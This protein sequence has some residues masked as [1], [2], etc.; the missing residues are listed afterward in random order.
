MTQSRADVI[1]TDAQIDAAIARANKRSPKLPRV[2]AAAYDHANDKVRVSL[3]NG[4]DVGF[5][6]RLIQGLTDARPDQLVKIQILGPGTGLFWPDLDVA[7][8]VLQMLTG[9]FGTRRWMAEIAARGGAA[10]SEKKAEAARINGAKSA[11]RPKKVIPMP[12]PD[13]KL[14]VELWLQANQESFRSRRSATAGRKKYTTAKKSSAGK[15][16]R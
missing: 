1:T 7:H 15:K 8:D 3:G 11:G 13:R 12:V 6:R 5:P 2:V 9:E 16:R 14:P 10:R 4:M